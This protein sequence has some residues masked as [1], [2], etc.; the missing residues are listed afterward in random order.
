MKKIILFFSLIP[1]FSIAQVGIGTTDP[2][3]TLDVNGAIT[4][5]EIS[6]AVASNA[7]TIATET[8]LANITG[9]ATATIAVT[10]FT[11]TV[12]GCRLII[13]NNTTG[14]FGATFAGMT[15]PNSQAI[16]FVYTNG[17]WKTTAGGTGAANNI[18]NSNGTLSGNRTV[19]QGASSLTFT[20][21]GNTILNSGN[22]GVGTATP[23]GKLNVSG[24]LV[25]GSGT[26]G[27]NTT[28]VPFSY[29]NTTN[30]AI[31][32]G[33]YD[34]TAASDYGVMYLQGT[35][36][37]STLNILTGDNAS[38]AA[39]DE[40]VF[41]GNVEF[42][43]GTKK[44]MTIKNGFAGIGT[45]APTAQL[46]TTGS[47]LFAGAGTP[48][49]GRS[50]VTDAT[51]LATWQNPLASNSTSTAIA[52][53]ATQVAVPSTNVQGAIGDLASAIRT[54]QNS[55]IYNS[56]GTL[57]GNRIVTQGTNTLT[58]NST[59]L[60]GFSVDGTTF[61][62][63]GA[64]DR[65]GIGTTN[66]TKKLTVEN[67]SIRPA[68][69]N[70]DD[71]GISFPT[72]IGGGGGDEAFIRYYVES[73]ENTK[74][75]IGINNDI[76]DD[77]SFF[78]A[79]AE[80]MNIYNGNIGIGINLPTAQLHTTGSVRFAGAGTPALGR[81]LVT[82]ATGL[83]TWQNPLASNTNNTAITASATQVA[84][85]ST[86]VQGAISD[87]ATAIKTNSSVNDWKLDGNSN[88][89]I[90][91]FGTIDAF[92]LPF[93]TNNIER[94]R[95]KSGGSI[96]IGT[97][98][99]LG[100]LNIAGGFVVGTGTNGANTTG[101]PFT[102]GDATNSAIW[103]GNYDNTASSDYGVMYLQPTAG[104]TA[105]LNII[106]GDNASGGA[107]DESVF[108]GNMDFS[109]TKKGVTVKNG[110]TGIGT[111][112]PTAQLHT[113]GS[114]L[115]AGAGTPALNRVLVSD[116]TGLAT[117][118]KQTATNTDSNAIAASTTQVAVSSTN[119]QGAIGDLATAIKTVSANDWKLDGNTNGA[120]EKF[121]TIDGFDVPFITGNVERMRILSS[122][123][124]GVGTTTAP[125]KLTISGN[126]PLGVD[127][128]STFQSKNSSGTYENFFWPRW[129]DDIMYLNYGTN[130]F[131][132]RN[133]SSV[134]S[135]FI[136]NTG[137]VGIGIT[138][139]NAPMQFANTIANRK[140]VLWEAANNDHQFYGF[141]INNNVLRYQVNTAS[142]NHIFY[143]GSS[144]TTSNEL[145][146]I[147]GNG[148]V[149]I[150][151]TNPT[152]K[153]TIENGSIRPAVGNSQDAGV[154]FPTNI[155]GGGGDEA[156]IRYYV[157][158]G[159]NTK[160]MIGV[161]ND[162]DDDISFYQGGAERMNIYNG[163]VGIGTTTPVAKLDLTGLKATGSG[164]GTGGS[165]D[166]PSQAI[167]PAGNNGTSR[168]NDWPAG[169]GGGIS[170][171]DIVGGSTFMNANLIRS[172]F[173]LKNDIKNIDNSIFSNF[174]KIRPVT[175]FMKEQTK[176]MEG[177][178][179]GFI[180]Q[181]IR[182]LFPSMVTKSTDP[183]GIIGM[184]YQAL[185]SPT[186][187]VVQQQ[188]AKIDELQK[189]VDTQNEKLSKMEEE[190]K[191]IKQLLSK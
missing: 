36:D 189:Q 138:T 166:N 41:I 147:Q 131:N 84:V 66:P 50:L 16:E 153:L 19:T 179:Y 27:G 97:A 76:D 92:D 58:F 99:P 106:A 110:F 124:I 47:V 52:A 164:T 128:G 165:N 71:S 39:S 81:S 148:N 86:N 126:L 101:I 156:F 23:L 68:I 139:P 49:L 22:V 168:F 132:I 118:Q 100:K 161:N 30:S 32:F 44:G 10:S 115:F 163:N 158:S 180:A 144:A 77:I 181:E 4:N 157:E 120:I 107:S 37:T 17:V 38:G 29:G 143:A 11:P 190:L 48:T 145:M 155:G 12:N 112:A 167:I 184:N 91:N 79:G 85:P 116:A 89:A 6:F 149:G 134:S 178:Q 95:I 43:S 136:A 57:T 151:S 5:R 135:M 63:D 177:L 154:Y 123:N 150:G 119:V 35:G 90:K 54:A 141:G 160:L 175:Y 46:H 108:I 83:A 1:L 185:I 51:G 18:Y 3:T 80:R 28:G 169:W 96:G 20:G 8:S 72:N 122:G 74:L 183:N 146:R 62:V 127:N 87:L 162:V 105:T 33:N 191:Q 13:S 102:F 15:I 137:N 24:G 64:N 2:R 187:Y 42:T 174:M 31:W 188:Q 75:S 93:I 7:V 111:I 67:G 25:I 125:H 140:I 65:I 21:T 176:E 40:S 53:S 133:N 59:V 45:T 130:G 9:S 129:S 55:T 14:G 70:T 172:D 103:F 170:T 121:G 98:N 159:E 60:N 171:Y 69:G 186:I 142:D 78:Q 152:K 26:G 104:D 114:V 109:G 34:N 88:G 113:T 182:D 73:G 94:M 56:N 117:W 173:R 61:S 82:D